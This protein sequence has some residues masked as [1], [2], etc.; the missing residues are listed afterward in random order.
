MLTQA[1]A[2]QEDPVH[3]CLAVTD[4]RCKLDYRIHECNVWFNVA[5]HGQD[6][7]MLFLTGNLFFHAVKKFGIKN[8]R[9]IGSLLYHRKKSL[10]SALSQDGYVMIKLFNRRW[11]WQPSSWWQKSFSE[12]AW[13]QS[14]WSP[15][16][17]TNFSGYLY[18]T[19][20]IFDRIMDPR[21][22]QYGLYGTGY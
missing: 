16:L 18:T 22:T 6:K 17:G 15:N 4:C 21:C 1:R 14:L 9:K 12:V 10:R 13:S 11:R 3:V 8:S 7:S 20:K 2:C 19:V 5:W